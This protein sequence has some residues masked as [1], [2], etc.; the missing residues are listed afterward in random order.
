MQKSQI[1]ALTDFFKINF[2]YGIQRKSN[3]E[4]FAFNRNSMPLGS[5]TTTIVSFDEWQK[6]F[7]GVRYNGFTEALLTTIA[8]GD[9]KRDEKGKIS[10]VT[11]YTDGTNPIN[12]PKHWDIYFSKLKKIGKLKVK[13]ERKN[14]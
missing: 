10:S 13:F 9:V 7:V 11:L 6:M 12:D 1:M 5:K 8:A 14:K 2:P 3:D 4:W